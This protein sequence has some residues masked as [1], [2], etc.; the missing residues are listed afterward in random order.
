M[1]PLSEGVLA[2]FD[3]RVAAW[4]FITE[5]LTEP[6][7]KL[8]VM[9]EAIAFCFSSG[10]EKVK[11]E[12]SHDFKKKFLDSLPD[13]LRACRDSHVLIWPVFRMAEW[14]GDELSGNR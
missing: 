14:D 5:P 11:V 1:A 10:A 9:L 8:R 13:Y 12:L 3:P 2:N 6:Q 7:N 4:E